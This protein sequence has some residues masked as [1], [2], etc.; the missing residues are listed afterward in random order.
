MCL[1]CYSPQGTELLARH[2]Y[3]EQ[4]M[5]TLERYLTAAAQTST[6]TPGAASDD[7]PDAPVVIETLET[8]TWAT[9]RDAGAAG[10]AAVARLHGPRLLVPFMAPWHPAKMRFLAA[11]VLLHMAEDSVG[12]ASCLEHPDVLA[13]C[14]DIITGS[15][16]K[17]LLRR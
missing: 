5:V 13:A 16:P 9:H 1:V 11:S 8:L 2:R 3:I 4:L 15:K 7:A 14:K 6:A 10:V 17:F 12:C